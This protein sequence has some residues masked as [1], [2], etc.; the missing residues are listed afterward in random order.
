MERTVRSVVIAFL[1]SGSVVGCSATA[2]PTDA[3]R[4]GPRG[5][6]GP[7]AAQFETAYAGAHSAYERDVLRDGAVSVAEYEQ[8]RSHVAS[9]LADAGYK[10]TYDA[11]G[12]FEL[13]SE[14]GSYPDDFFEHSDPV[15]QTCERRWD[16]S[17]RFLYEQVRRNPEQL[18]EAA[19]AVRCLRAAG[20]VDG[21]YTDDRW[22]EENA[23]DDWSFDA[24]DPAAEAC[25]LDPL[26]RWYRR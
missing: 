21:S 13:G 22:N 18:D 2:T 15:L 17:I 7:W 20:L 24:L 8:T 10:I 11:T 1:V 4:G 19:I 14:D 25:R 9:C 26:G 6:E 3:A 16:G 5:F 23:R 12:G